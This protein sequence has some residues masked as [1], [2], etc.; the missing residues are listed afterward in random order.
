[1]KKL[2][3]V[4][5]TVTLLAGFA[6]AAAAEAPWGT[7]YMYFKTE[8]GKSLNVR[9]SPNKGDNVIG[10]AAYGS[11]IL[12]DWSYAGNDGWTKVFWD[13]GS[14]YVMTRFLTS[15]KPGPAPKPS[16]EE[17]EELDE[18]K[19]LANELASEKAAEVPFYISV[20]ATR[21]SGW[22]NFRTGPSKTTARI[23]SYPDGK[24]LIAI[25]ETDNWFK[26]R[27]PET[28][29]VGY[30]HKSFVTKLNKQYVT[31]V[32]TP[33]GVKKLGSLNVNGDF[34]LTCKLAEGYDVQAVNVRGDKIIAS[35]LSDD[36]T[37]PQMYLSIA[38]DETYGDVERM[39]DLS[40]EDLAILEGTFTDMNEVVISY[41]ETGHGTK[42]LIAR[43]TGG[44]TDF[45]DI[46]AIYKGY[47]IEF[48]MTPNPKAAD[49]TLTD[50]QI[51][52]CIDFLTDVDFN[53][54]Q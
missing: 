23:K 17:Q 19:K 18:K 37:R 10:H 2:L 39:N 22:I 50:E 42:L 15:E 34:E 3:S 43:E 48:N 14:G 46:L 4:L 21:A 36:I 47:F 40:D 16:P 6:A 28:D 12:T 8:N 5:L 33:D 35:I 7:S 25:G 24:E 30:I 54:V 26:A 31:E 13:G 44:D 45:V 20:R 49:Q 9:S 53:P 41:A 11:R 38:Y 32:E 29:K 27:D 51:R 1:M 52:M